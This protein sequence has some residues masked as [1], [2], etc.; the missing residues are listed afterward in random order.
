[1]AQTFAL[2]PMKRFDQAK[3]RLRGQLSDGARDA[4]ARSMFAR[5]LAAADGCSAIDRVAVLTNG[6]EVARLAADAGAHVLPDPNP[7]LDSLGALIDRAWSQLP[8]LGAERAVVLM[9]DLPYLDASD[10]AALAAALDGSDLALV[11]DRRGHSTNALALRLP[12]RFASAFGQAESY[13][14]HLARATEHGLVVAQL[15]QP[16]IAH[17]VD[18]PEDLPD[19]SARGDAFATG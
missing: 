12:A 18:I 10:V 15:D 8:A 13:R 17:D 5:V 4:L 3:S 1:M 14:L 11:K 19:P 7:P 9:A 16:R 2:I 6:D